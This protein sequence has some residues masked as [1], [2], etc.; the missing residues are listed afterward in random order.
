MKSTNE[1]GCSD[2][3]QTLGQP[4]KLDSLFLLHNLQVYEP[5]PRLQVSPKDTQGGGGGGG[6]RDGMCDRRGEGCHRQRGRVRGMG[7]EA[8]GGCRKGWQMEEDEKWG[9]WERQKD[10]EEKTR[11]GRQTQTQRGRK[12]DG[13]TEG[14]LSQSN[15]GNRQHLRSIICVQCVIC[16]AE[17]QPGSGLGCVT[18]L[19][20]TAKILRLPE[21]DIVLKQEK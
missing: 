6:R 17:R 1:R 21:Q 2:A 20:P 7:A 5:L 8:E 9:A 13:K 16:G 18:S 15:Q 11:R 19:P 4:P 12:A 10:G 3:E 14:K